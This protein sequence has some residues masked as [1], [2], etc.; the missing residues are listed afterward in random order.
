MPIARTV[1]SCLE[2][3]RVP[4]EIISHPHSTTSG[5]T[6]RVAT[7]SPHQIA[8]SVILGDEQGYLMAVV[9]GDCQVDVDELS[10]RLGRRLRLVN[11]ATF[12][13]LFNDCELGAVP[14]LGPA[15]GVETIIDDRLLD[16]AQICFVAGDHDELVRVEREAFRRL[17]DGARHALIGRTAPVHSATAGM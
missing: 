7:V 4:Y 15:Y 12:A 2:R 5:E 1:E 10:H 16:E 17:T 11:E 6:A 9:P 3:H 14:P 8:K 13:H